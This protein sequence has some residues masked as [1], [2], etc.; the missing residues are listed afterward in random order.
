MNKTNEEAVENVLEESVSRPLVAMDK[1]TKQ[2]GKKPEDGEIVEGI[3]IGEEKLALYIDLA[4]FGTG[5]IYGREYITA[6]DVIRKVN[7]GDT[8]SAKVVMAEN[9][10]GYVELSLKEARQAAI[11]SEAENALRKKSPLEVSVKDA[12]KGG[13]MIDWQGIPGFLPAS[14]L[15]PDHYPRVED[16]DKDSI[17]R[18]LKKLIGTKIS[19][20]IITSDQ[21]EGKLIFSEKTGN[22]K[23]RLE[24]VS[25]YN[26]GD[27]LDG[28]VTGAVDFGI[29]VKIEDGLEGLVHISEI[30]WAL[31]ENPKSLYKQGDKVSVKVIDI[32]DGKLSLSIKALKENP[33]EKAAA[34][35]TKDSIVEG[36]V[37]KH[38]R[39]GALVAIEEGVA[40][41]V[42][43]SEFATEE[44]LRVKL[45]LGKTYKFKINVFEPKEQRMTLS[46][47]DATV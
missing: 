7:P 46:L 13:L 27:T 36:V 40:G 25:K 34:K 6:R 18:E 31:V 2:S 8:I 22:E 47:S 29:F 42:H 38:N 21:K 39:H 28:V 17:L 23:E 19:V 45:E 16:G 11:W 32:K 9:E 20:T 30:D 33:W 35:Y 26:T 43:V 24:L 4:P 15:S 37:I 12:N 1:I 5:I 41:L 44:A 14:Q 10:D 3:V